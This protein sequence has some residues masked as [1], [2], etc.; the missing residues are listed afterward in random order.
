MNNLR[1]L[2]AIVF[3]YNGT[4]V[5]DVKI[6]AESYWRAGVDM[7]FD[8][9][10]EK[11]W[12]HVSQPPSRKRVLYYGDISDERWKAVFALKK[13][14][15]YEIAK[16]KSIVFSDAAG[17]LTGLSRRY[18]LAVLSNT[19]RFFFEG[20]FPQSLAA[21]FDTTL[22]F[23][24]VAVPKPA[25]DPMMLMLKRLGVGA[26]QCCYVGDAIEDIQMAR[27]AG[28]HVISIAT[29]GCS[30]PEL[31]AAGPDRVFDSLAQMADWLIGS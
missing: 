9:T 30:K 26:R 15:Y 28:T 18:K 21:L 16:N 12:Q 31:E 22:F 3:D 19:F 4:L 6:H 14:H 25:P 10:K 24:E 29:G 1:H 2:Q 11:V 7:G 13:K 5:D 23:D 27:A 17:A 20:F 8:L